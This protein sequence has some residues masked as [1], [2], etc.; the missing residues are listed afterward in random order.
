MEDFP[1]TAGADGLDRRSLRR[2][3]PTAKIWAA[4]ENTTRNEMLGM[5]E[6]ADFSGLGL[7]LRGVAGDPVAALGDHLW[8]TLVADEGIIPVRALLVHIKG[9][10]LFGLRLDAPNAPGQHFLLRL[11]ERVAS[12]VSTDSQT[13]AG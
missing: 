3:T 12:S 4:V 13:A 9:Q 5:A 2:I 8:I 1:G 7:S 11:Y 6:V 10:N